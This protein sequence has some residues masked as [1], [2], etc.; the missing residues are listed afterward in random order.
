MNYRAIA[1]LG[2]LVAAG[3]TGCDPYE[4]SPGGTPTVIG[5][6]LSDGGTASEG[7]AVGTAWTV[8]GDD[9]A[10]NALTIIANKLLDPAS[11]QASVN[12]CTPAGGWLTVTGPSITCTTGTPAWYSCYMPSSPTPAEGARIVVFQACEPAVDGGWY[13]V[14]ELVPAS[15]YHFTGN[16]K[17]KDGTAMPI[18]VTVNTAAEPPPAP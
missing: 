14:G 4:S 15:T 18:D 5:A 1:V 13:D 11:I 16:V 2:A 7:T 3:I 6:V 17:D 12:D 8:T 9:A 10:Q